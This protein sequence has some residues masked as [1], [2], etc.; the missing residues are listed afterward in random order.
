M[1][2]PGGGAGA[3]A[4]RARRRPATLAAAARL[5]V[6]ARAQRGR[7]LRHVHAARQHLARPRAASSRRSIKAAARGARP[8]STGVLT[9]LGRPEDGTDPTLPNNLEIFVK[10]KPLDEWRHDMHTLER[11]R[12]RDERRTSQEIPGIEYNFSQPIRDN[13]AENISGQFGQIA[14]KIYGDDLDELQDAR[15]EGRGRDRRRPRRRRPRHREVAAS[16]RR[17]P[18]SSIA[19]RSRASTSIS[20][21]CRTTSRRRWAGHVA[22]ELWEGE[23]RFD[24]TVRLPPRDARGRRR[25]PR[26]C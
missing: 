11:P 8:R 12:R 22:S 5:G 19:T 7:A 14:L 2:Q 26:A 18:S 6:L 9:Q 3:R 1:K 24:V 20:A 15:R 10:L 25:D 13:V 4:R 17:S 23:K 21:T 16:R